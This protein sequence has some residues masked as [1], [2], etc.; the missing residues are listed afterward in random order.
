M[1]FMARTLSR[2]SDSTAI[3]A[4]LA[5]ALMI[6]HVTIDI[7]MRFA[8]NMPLSG[9]ILSVSLFY[10]PMVV[11]LP[12]AYAEK[13]KSHISMEL[14]YDMLPR[15]IQRSLDMLSHVLSLIVFGALAAR[16][17]GE[18]FTKMRIGAAEMEGSLRIPTWP[19]YFCL[20][21]GF[22]LLVSLLIFR[23]A[24]VATRRPDELGSHSND[25]IEEMRSV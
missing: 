22:A 7:F 24:C 17:W 12:L 25:P 15:G 20:P 23:A 18:A 2:L 21:L 19:G 8:F 4:G 10:M 5:V 1:P 14:V 9:T 13:N 6:I 3:L 16:T 11:F